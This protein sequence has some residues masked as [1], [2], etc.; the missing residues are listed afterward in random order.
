MKFVI[1]TQELNFLINKIQNV[2]PQK[3][4]IP[5]LSNFLIEASNGMLTLTATDLT[6]GIRC[7]TEANV[8]EEGATTLP[9]K[10]FAQLI[11]ELTQSQVEITTSEQEITEIKAN[12]SRFKL[13]GMKAIEFPSLPDMSGATSFKMPQNLLKEMLFR[14]SFAISRDDNRYVLTGASMRVAN[15]QA[16]FLGTDGKRLARAHTE[17]NVDNAF[18]GNYIIPLKAIDEVSKN[19]YEEG[20]VTVYLMQDKIAFEIAHTTIITKLLSGDY[21]DVSRVIP[22]RTN[23]VVS[24]HREE[25]TSLLRQVSLFTKDNNHSVRFTFNDGDLRLSANAMEIG[26]GKVSMPVN[27]HGPRVDIAFNPGFFLDILRHSKEETVTMGITDAFNPGVI[28]DQQLSQG[29]AEKTS[30]LFVIMPMRLNDED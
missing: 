25:L 17:I 7:Q 10:R 14:T 30:P 12:T 21:P 1:S 11:R 15:K 19:L 8:I 9:A 24:L 22:E 29:F 13:H 23:M 27:Y 6:V 2:V 5:I 18:T 20:E 4:T 3:A 16:V 28:T 26:E